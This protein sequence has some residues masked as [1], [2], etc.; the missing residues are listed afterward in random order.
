MK[1][2]SGCHESGEYFPLGGKEVGVIGKDMRGNMWHD[3]R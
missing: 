1:E 3:G 2:G